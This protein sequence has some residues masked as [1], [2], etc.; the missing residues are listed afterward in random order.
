MLI[1]WYIQYLCYQKRVIKWY[2]SYVWRDPHI[3]GDYGNIQV[4]HAL[5]GSLW[6][7]HIHVCESSAVYVMNNVQN[8]YEPGTAEQR[9]VHEWWWW[10]AYAYCGM[11]RISSIIHYGVYT[12]NVINY[13]V[14]DAIMVNVGISIPANI[15]LYRINIRKSVTL[16]QNSKF[17]WSDKQKHMLL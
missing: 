5:V 14:V 3:N 11:S 4:I 16:I 17:S 13:G 10:I 1:R 15:F 12:T 6:S 7:V 8:I 9:S 2:N